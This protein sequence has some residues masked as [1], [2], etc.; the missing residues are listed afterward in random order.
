MIGLKWLGHSWSDYEYEEQR[1]FLF[2]SVEILGF[3]FLMFPF[4]TIKSAILDGN[5]LDNSQKT[6]KTMTE[7]PIPRSSGGKLHSHQ[8][9]RTLKITPLV[10][11]CPNHHF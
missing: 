5:N 4:I 11:T 8:P 1:T 7:L 9:T 6:K 10:Q 3:S 2:S